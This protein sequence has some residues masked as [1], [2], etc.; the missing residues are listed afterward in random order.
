MA[1]PMQFNSI[2]VLPN[3]VPAITV[4]F[5]TSGLVQQ[6]IISRVYSLRAVTHGP[7]S[8]A[9]FVDKTRFRSAHSDTVVF[10]GIFMPANNPAKNALRPAVSKSALLKL[11]VFSGNSTPP[12]IWFNSINSAKLISFGFI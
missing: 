8:A 1:H 12:R 9:Y 4:I 10:G 6:S 3:C 11:S 2:S 7:A 5:S